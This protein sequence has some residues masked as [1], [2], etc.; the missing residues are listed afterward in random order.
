MTFPQSI[1]G[2]HAGFMTRVIAGNEAVEAG[3][4]VAER[5]A[6]GAR[7]PVIAGAAIVR[8]LAP[9]GIHEPLNLQPLQRRVERPFLDVKH[10]ARHG[11]DMLRDPVPVHHAD[12]QRLEDQHV[13]R[14]RQEFF[15][16]LDV[17]FP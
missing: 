15:A 3:F 9:L 10:L 16:S 13:E 1:Y 11:L 8:G 17:C 12:R 14:A 7:Q 4:G 2:S 6:A 5:T